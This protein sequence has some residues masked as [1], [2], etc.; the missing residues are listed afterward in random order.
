MCG[1]FAMD[2]KTD[3]LI[4]EFVADGGRAEDWAGS[5]SIAPTTTAPIIRERLVDDVIHREIDLARWDWDRPASRPKVPII[6]ARME[7]LPERFWVG[8]FSRSRCIV[9]MLGYY[10]WTGEKGAKIPHWIHSDELLA[11]AGLTWTTEIA[12]ERQRV[13]VVVT[14][15]ARDASG[16][17]HDR[18]PAFLTDELRDAWLDPHPLTVDGDVTASRSNRL[19]LLDELEAS[20]SMIATTMRTH[21]V[22]RK[23]NNARTADPT[24]RSL[25]EAA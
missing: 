6:N 23:V 14:R 8:P 24:D 13:F 20:S 18:M 16:E 10:E 11:A 5:Y 22:D 4:R 21:I 15:E 3:E 12:G 1:R 17:I 2:K 9:P 7:K 19:Q 25:I